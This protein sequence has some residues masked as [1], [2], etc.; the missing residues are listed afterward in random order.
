MSAMDPWKVDREHAEAV[1]RTGSAQFDEPVSVGCLSCGAAGRHH[2][3]CQQCPSC[4]SV[5]PNGSHAPWCTEETPMQRFERTGEK[6]RF[7]IV[8]GRWV[9]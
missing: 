4:W 9:R 8:A 1:S 3:W 2:Y 6:W 7:D 5:I